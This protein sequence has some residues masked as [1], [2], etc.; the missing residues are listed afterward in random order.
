M[1]THFLISVSCVLAA[2]PAMAASYS[3]DFHNGHFDNQALVPMGRGAVNLLAPTNEGLRI[4]IPAGHD[5]KTVGFSPRFTIR[6]DFEV[7]VEFTIVSRTQPKSGFGTGPSVYLSTGSTQDPAASL[8]RLLRPDGRDV[9]GLFAARVEEGE[10]VPAAKLFDVPAGRVQTGR[11][12]LKRV[13]NEITYSVAD[14]RSS[15]LLAL[16]VLPMGD[17][18]VTM[19]RVGVSQ[20]DPQSAAAVVLHNIRIEAAELP[21]LP[22][23]RSRTAQLYRPRYHAPPAPASYLWLWQ[24]LAA[25]LLVSGAATW[26][27]RR[28]R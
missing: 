13:K 15:P 3:W 17:S 27:W 16:A 28:D 25:V 20:S 24:S 7:T 18:E 4:T 22:S 8:G 23:E 12:Q 19:L 21:H 9:Y 6:G 11:L 10:R 2:A 26:W 1:P 14:D 5:V